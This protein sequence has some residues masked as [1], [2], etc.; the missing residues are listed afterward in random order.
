MMGHLRVAYVT[1]NDPSDR[2][3]WSGLEYY[4]A[5]TVNKYI[6]GVTYVG[7]LTSRVTFRHH[8]K[9]FYYK[10]HHKQYLAER[11]EEMGAWYAQQIEEKLS[12]SEFDLIF[13]PSTIPIAHLKTDLPIVVWLDATFAIMVDYYFK[14]LCAESIRDGNSM[15]NNA[16]KRCAFICFASKWAA[17]SAVND[18]NIETEK[19]KVIPFGANFDTIPEKRGIDNRLTIPLELLFIAKDWYRKGGETVFQTFIALNDMGIESNLSVVGCVPPKKFRHAQMK[20]FPFLDKNV[21]VDAQQLDCLYR[22]AH[23]II[24]PSREECYGLVLCEANAY[25]VPVLARN[26]GGI[27]E[28][29]RDGVNGFLMPADALGSDYAFKIAGLV[30]DTESYIELCSSSRERFEEVLNWDAGGESL[31]DILLKKI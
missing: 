31:R 7:N 3:T 10:L 2:N 17:C 20:I 9:R 4:I 28:I 6:G 26:T 11:T 25:G 8:V 29:I 12:R 18:Y 5:K 27:S 19:V 24:L 23:F 14:K 15:E 30:R 16:F 22:N 1:V 13:S 21:S